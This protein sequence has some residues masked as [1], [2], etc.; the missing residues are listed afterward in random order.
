MPLWAQ[1]VSKSP[2]A[3]AVV[4]GVV[5]ILLILV[6]PGGAS[7]LFARLQQLI[8]PLTT[9]SEALTLGGYHRAT[10]FDETDVQDYQ[11]DRLR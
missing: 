7:G 11:G 5:L 1:N 2:G 8:A 9:L 6:L 10:R 4:Y 3:P